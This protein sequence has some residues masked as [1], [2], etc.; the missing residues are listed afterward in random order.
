MSSVQPTIVK[1]TKAVIKSKRKFV[2]PAHLFVQ[3]MNAV[4]QGEPEAYYWDIAADPE[5]P[6]HLVMRIAKRLK[7]GQDSFKHVMDDG[8]DSMAG[9]VDKNHEEAT[10][11]AEEVILYLESK[12][13]PQF[14]YRPSRCG[15]PEAFISMAGC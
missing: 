2:R 12:S 1:T 9:L 6:E 14:E 7:E 5:A 11:R 15:R 3:L 13:I 4:E 10:E 8:P